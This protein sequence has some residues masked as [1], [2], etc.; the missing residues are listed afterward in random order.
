MTQNILSEYTE[1]IDYINKCTDK[2]SEFISEQRTHR[3]SLRKPNKKH[4]PLIAALQQIDWEKSLADIRMGRIILPPKSPKRPTHKKISTKNIHQKTITQKN[5]PKSPQKKSFS[6]KEIDILLKKI[7]HKWQWQIHSLIRT[8]CYP[9]Q[10]STDWLASVAQFYRD[11]PKS[12]LI[13][14]TTEFIAEDSCPEN[15]SVIEQLQQELTELKKQNQELTELLQTQDNEMKNQNNK[16]AQLTQ[17]VLNFQSMSQYKENKRTESEGKILLQYGKEIDLY[18]NEILSFIRQSLDYS[19]KN[20]VHEHSRH[21][22]ILTDLL[23][24]NPMEKD[25]R[26]T[27]EAELHKIMRTYSRMDSP[28]RQA[29]MNLGFQISEDGT[30]FKLIFEND[31]RYTFTTSKTSSDNRGGRNFARDVANLLF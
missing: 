1:I 21:Q 5:K 7:R 14:E 19:L 10:P 29:L 8:E 17:Q 28:T 20:Q 23:E 22:H 6:S 31:K 11:T 3:N 13:P 26:N 15:D 16:I 4:L 2:F 12:T 9:I 25:W 24:A 18:E 27:K 30:H